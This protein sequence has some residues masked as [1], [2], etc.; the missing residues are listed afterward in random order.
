MAKKYLTEKEMLLQNRKHVFTLDY[1]ISK[2]ELSIEDLDE[3]LPGYIHINRVSDMN[4]VYVSS[5]GCDKF[6]RTNNELVENFKDLSDLY[7]DIEFMFKNSF[8]SLIK[9]CQLNDYN[10]TFSFLEKL[11]FNPKND[12]ELYLTDIKLIKETQN[13]ICVTNPVSKLSY[14][15]ERLN[16]ISET[17]KF[18]NDNFEKFISLTK[19]EKE[20]LTLLAT[21]Y[22]NK[23]IGERLFISIDTVKTHK[24][25]IA[26]KLQAKSFADLV[27]CAV[28]FYLI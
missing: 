17:N 21:G 5:S 11:R 22:Q 23:E 19:R 8:Q 26:K 6:E 20:I 27:Q 1:Q 16:S 15:T 14:T 28:T 7:S 24:Q 18:F 12:F 10:S 3:L 2:R 9:Y 4:M 13:L 25:H